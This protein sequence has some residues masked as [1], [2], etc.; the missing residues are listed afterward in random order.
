MSES[1]RSTFNPFCLEIPQTFLTKK[2]NFYKN[3][4][5]NRYHLRKVIIWKNKKINKIYRS[6]QIQTG[7]CRHILLKS[8][9]HQSQTSFAWLLL[10]CQASLLLSCI[11]P[12]C[13]SFIPKYYSLKLFL[14]TLISRPWMETERRNHARVF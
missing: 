9:T 8:N 1:K 6:I 13:R 11:T 7:Q 3:I 14:L 2:S 10:R 12:K 5:T 4:I